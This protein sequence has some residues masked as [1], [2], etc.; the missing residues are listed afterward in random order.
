MGWFWFKTSHNSAPQTTQAAFSV[1]SYNWHGVW[2]WG[3]TA[4]GD[5][6]GEKAPVTELRDENETDQKPFLV[7]RRLTAWHLPSYASD[8]GG[9]CAFYWQNRSLI[10]SGFCHSQIEAWRV[11]EPNP[12]RLHS[13]GVRDAP[14]RVWKRSERAEIELLLS[15]QNKSQRAE[16]WGNGE[17]QGGS[18]NLGA[19]KRIPI[20]LRIL[21]H[22]AGE[23]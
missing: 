22:V 16:K 23:G 12:H 10:G 11:L 1:K 13:S 8:L 4:R 20:Y 21:Q 14:H 2:R 6:V 15:F 17:A 3:S 19:A 18:G 5:K 9:K 7:W